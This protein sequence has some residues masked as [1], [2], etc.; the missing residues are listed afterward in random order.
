MVRHLPFLFPLPSEGTDMPRLETERLILRPPEYSD[1]PAITRYL[2]EFDVSKNLGDVCHPFNETDA[3]AFVT[4]AHERR[5]LGEGFCFAIL[6]KE[7]ED[8]FGCCRL[9]LAE[10]RYK[11]GY[12][13]GKPYWN[14]GYAT[15]AARKLAGFAFH[16]LKVDRIWA[17]WFADNPASGRVLE[18]LGF[19]PVETYLGPSLARGASVP[20]NRTTLL[21]AEFGRKRP[22]LDRPDEAVAA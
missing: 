6:D 16:D 21:R 12:W 8:F 15:E 4:A 17:S 1:V 22:R 10:G 2:G 7:S 18:K 13:L 9:T 14:R 5:A 11:L 20:C 19:R 3:R